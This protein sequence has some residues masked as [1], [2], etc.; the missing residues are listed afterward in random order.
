MKSETRRTVDLSLHI[1]RTIERGHPADFPVDFRMIFFRNNDTFEPI[2]KRYAV[3]REDTAQPISIVSDR[4]ALIP[5]QRILD[6]IE[7]AIRPLGV[8]QVP[9]GIFVDRQGAR[10]RALFKFPALEQ[11]IKAGD[12]ICPCLKIQNTYDGTSRISIHIGAF[13]FVCTNLAVG[14]GG[15]F[16]GGFMS[17]HAGEIPIDKMADELASYLKQFDSIVEVYRFWAAVPITL[18]EIVDLFSG[19]NPLRSVPSRHM[20]RMVERL[21]N[22][23]VRTAFDAYNVATDYATHNMRS[24][25]TAF[26]L[27]N[28]INSGFQKLFPVKTEGSPGSVA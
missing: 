8:G 22:P 14:G 4:Y 10:M 12:S 20:E 7:D 15:V 27:L 25:Q 16:A 21:Q 6:T 1:N 19:K 11:P 18:A 9:R 5:H 17:I 26:D 3:V 2:S 24:Y 13:R 28:R 23:A